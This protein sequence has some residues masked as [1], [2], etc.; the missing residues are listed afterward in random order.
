MR[1]A[2]GSTGHADAT[3][4]VVGVSRLKN[5]EEVGFFAGRSSGCDQF[6]NNCAGGNQ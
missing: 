3:S 5:G 1:W 2:A 6:S 4:C